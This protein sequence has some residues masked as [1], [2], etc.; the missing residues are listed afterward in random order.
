MTKVF[1]RTAPVLLLAALAGCGPNYSP[2]TYASNAVQQANK[3]EQGIV[4]GVRAVEISA[5]GTVGTVSG[6]AA[7]GIAGSQAT[8]GVGAA[9]TALGGGVLGG[10]LGNEIEHQVA[11]T[12]GFEYIVRK[13]KGDLV[14]VA[15]KDATPLAL[16][17]HVL[18]IAGPQARIVPDYTVPLEPPKPAT[19]MAEPPPAS[20]PQP[21]AAAPPPPA[22]ETPVAVTPLPAP[23]AATETAP[24]DAT[25]RA[26]AP[27][28]IKPI[29]PS[30]AGAPPADAPPSGEAA[31]PERDL[32]D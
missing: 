11:D 7:G 24:P 29:E 10:I 6:A 18:V 28:E 13:T 30:A 22:S 19:T 32:P 25:A 9:L 14:S 20:P 1:A 26:E 8:G 3:V 23:P 4:V 12:N 27:L 16:G 2:D 15:Q 21:T 17:T 5:P 31:P